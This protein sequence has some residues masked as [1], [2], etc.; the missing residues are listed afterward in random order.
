LL[1]KFLSV[2]IL[3]GLVGTLLA[4]VGIALLVIANEGK[5]LLLSL[6]VLLGHHG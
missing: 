1:I 4:I 6:L 2:K 5:G 3:D